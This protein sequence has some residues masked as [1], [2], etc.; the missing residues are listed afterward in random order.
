MH[1]KVKNIIKSGVDNY[2]KSKKGKE[3]NYHVLQEIFPVERRIRSII[4]GLET[5]FGTTVWEPLA[6]Y[7]AEQNGFTIK[8]EKKFE[9]PK[10]LPKEITD[11]INVWAEKRKESKSEIHLEEYIEE[12]RKVIKSLNLDYSKVEYTK[13]TSGQGID[14]WIEKNGIEYIVDIKTTQIN[15]GDGIKFNDH[16][17][18]WYAYRIFKDPDVNINAF[19]AIPFNPFEKAWDEVMGNR[20]KP[21]IFNKDIITDE[22]FWELIS[23]NKDTYKNIIQS[24]KELKAENLLQKYIDV[25]Y[26]ND[27]NNQAIINESKYEIIKLSNIENYIESV[28]PDFFNYQDICEENEE[29]MYTQS[30]N[31]INI[32]SLKIYIRQYT[33][34]SYDESIKDYEPQEIGYYVFDSE[35]DELTG[36]GYDMEECIQNQ[37]FNYTERVKDNIFCEIVEK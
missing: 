25:I 16:I 19:I 10:D 28:N 35:T 6:K 36:W 17:L 32:P 29:Y 12:L 30:I 14:L 1:E 7:L 9:M 4:G 37:S 8:N 20:A 24:F 34:Y 5:S 21:L 13:L 23:G 33:Y 31:Y 11:L 26:G 2:L 3:V 22:K 15:K 27:S 18:R